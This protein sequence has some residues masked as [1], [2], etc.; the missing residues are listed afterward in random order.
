[1]VQEILKIDGKL[2]V[3]HVGAIAHRF[4]LPVKTAFEYL[5]SYKIILWDSETCKQNSRTHAT[6]S[7][8]RSSQKWLSENPQA[9]MNPFQAYL[10][11]IAFDESAPLL[12]ERLTIAAY[13]HKFGITPEQWGTPGATLENHWNTPLPTGGQLIRWRSLIDAPSMRTSPIELVIQPDGRMQLDR[14]A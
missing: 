12:P 6:T 13:A 4:D 14:A 9:A 7:V 1:M 2:N 11:V 3:V 8:L 5:V 10:K